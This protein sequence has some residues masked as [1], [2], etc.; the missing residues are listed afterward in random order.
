MGTWWKHNFRRRSPEQFVLQPG[1]L[2]N[3]LV[4]PVEE[5]TVDVKGQ[6]DA[7]VPDPLLALTILRR[8]QLSPFITSRVPFLGIDWP[9]KPA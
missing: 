3:V 7:A 5:V 1:H 8:E 2:Q 9:Q 4:A 6:R